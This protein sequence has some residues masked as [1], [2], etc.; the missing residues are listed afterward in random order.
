MGIRFGIGQGDDASW[1]RKGKIT[2]DEYT[3]SDP[4]G[5]SLDID[6][7]VAF[8]NS[9]GGV[10]EKLRWDNGPYNIKLLDETGY[11]QSPSGIYVY[12][13]DVSPQRL[14]GIEQNAEIP[15][16][17]GP[18]WYEND[19]SIRRFYFETTHPTTNGN[20]SFPDTQFYKRT[21]SS[22]DYWMAY[23]STHNIKGG[24]PGSV[25]TGPSGYTVDLS[26]I[27]VE[28]IQCTKHWDSKP[29]WNGYKYCLTMSTDD[30]NAINYS[31]YMPVFD[32]FG[33]KYTAF[34]NYGVLGTAQQGIAK[35]TEDE[36]IEM[37]ENGFEI[38][39][40][41]WSH[42]SN[43]QWLDTTQIKATRLVIR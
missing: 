20:L 7:S 28:D 38:G 23:L 32:E 3:D 10:L 34:L 6:N 19:Q 29:I 2:S 37:A 21:I 13:D 17:A 25:D 33:W 15:D 41:T 1:L 4:T 22:T 40:H 35:M 27:D 31:G 8:I 16:G 30:G 36:A 11:G 9:M 43:D 14:G 39:N 42:W 24:V 12:L 5:F 26:T 18:H